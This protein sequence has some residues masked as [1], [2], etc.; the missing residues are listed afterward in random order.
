MTAEST[1]RLMEAITNMTTRLSLLP[2][3]TTEAG[4]R[5]LPDDS[6]GNDNMPD[7]ARLGRHS[8]FPAV[9]Q[10]ATRHTHAQ[11]HEPSR[12]LR[13]GHTHSHADRAA[14]GSTVAHMQLPAISDRSVNEEETAY[15]N[16]VLHRCEQAFALLIKTH[17][18]LYL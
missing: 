10:Y 16:H 6:W 9:P 11:H 15:Y 17:L 5:P 1:A 18:T 12:V 8:T 4:S 13:D 2:D 3:L 14:A 7:A